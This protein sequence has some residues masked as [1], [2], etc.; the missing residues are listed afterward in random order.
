MVINMFGYKYDQNNIRNSIFD[1]ENIGTDNKIELINVK[2]FVLCDHACEIMK[3]ERI[4]LPHNRHLGAIQC[5]W[6]KY[7]NSNTRN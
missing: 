3:S 7:D 1:H 2:A 6:V 4:W 5:V